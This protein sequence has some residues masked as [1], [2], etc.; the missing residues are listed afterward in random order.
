MPA[1]LTQLLLHVIRYGL[2]EF[3]TFTCSIFAFVSG[4]EHLTEAFLRRL[5]SF[6]VNTLNCAGDALSGVD[7]DKCQDR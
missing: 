7:G 2:S 6:R 3:S 1:I 5:A 4:L